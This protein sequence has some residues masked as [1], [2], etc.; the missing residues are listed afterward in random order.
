[1]EQVI[2]LKDLERKAYKE[3]QKDG[4]MEIMLGIILMAFG[5]F[6]YSVVF[7]FYIV[8]IIFAGHIVELIR[9]RHTYP[10]IGIVRLQKEEPKSSM[11]GVFYFLLCVFGIIAVLVYFSGD[12]TDYR[13]WLTWFPLLFGLVLVGPLM[14]AQNKSGSHRFTVYAILAL[15]MGAVFAIIEIGSAETDLM[16]YLVITGAVLIITGIGIFIHFLQTHPK[17]SWGVDDGA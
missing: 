8:L 3:S 13:H 4:L 17:G 12:I 2:D 10:R 16:L 11:K 9:R 5:G 7:V 14:Y 6:F 15:V 1:M